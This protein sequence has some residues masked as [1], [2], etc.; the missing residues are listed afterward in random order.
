MT[1]AHGS[2]ETYDMTAVDDLSFTAARKGTAALN[3]QDRCAAV[4]PHLSLL[5]DSLARDAGRDQYGY[6]YAGAP[7][8]SVPARRGRP[9]RTAATGGLTLAQW[10]SRTTSV[11]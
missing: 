10:M 3:G 8:G 11:R 6:R 1:E 2:A 4:A 7:R 9:A 5:R